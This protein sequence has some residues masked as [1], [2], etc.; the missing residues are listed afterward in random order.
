MEFRQG[1]KKENEEKGTYLLSLFIFHP[2]SVPHAGH[3]C[4]VRG[5]SVELGER[6]ARDEAP[7]E[8]E[9]ARMSAIV[10]E[11]LVSGALGFSSSRTILH[12]SIDGE[13]VPGTSATQE[14]L[15][16]IGRAMGR[17]GH[18]VFEIA[19]DL[20]PEWNEFEWMGALSR[21]T[22]L[23]VTFAALQSLAKAMPLDR[24][25]SEMEKQNAQGANIVA[26]LALRGNGI[27]MAWRGTIH[28]FV[29]HPGWMAKR[30]SAILFR[31]LSMITTESLESTVLGQ[32]IWGTLILFLRDTFL[33]AA[34]TSPAAQG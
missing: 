28:P 7:T 11:G 1:R 5:P 10:E 9:I 14:E 31:A 6:G 12:R 27:V 29:R 19:S 13:L 24:Q 18:G 21:E 4:A 22:G 30:L 20:E 34:S 26:Q 33:S 25:I 16:G 23:P 15:I 17:V 3:D 2:V 32:T 8:D